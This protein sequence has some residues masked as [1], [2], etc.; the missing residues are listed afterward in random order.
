MRDY[1]ASSVDEMLRRQSADSMVVGSDKRC[2]QSRDGPVYQHVWNIP[3][4]N[5]LEQI[6]MVDR[7]GGS[8]DETIHLPSQK[9]F[10][11]T[12][13]QFGIFFE[14]GNDHVVSMRPHRLRHS[15]SDLGKEGMSE[16][17]QQKSDGVSSPRDQAASHPI[18]LIIELLRPPQDAFARGHAD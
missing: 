17:G 15:P 2:L 16:I 7:L 12:Q 8:D 5:S 1:A 6:E 13:F 9:R 4:L 18:H 11:L 10:G 14:I 3:P